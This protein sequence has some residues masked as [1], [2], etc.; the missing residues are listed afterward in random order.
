MGCNQSRHHKDTR[1]LRTEVIVD[2]LGGDGFF[3][4]SE[5]DVGII[6]VENSA[7][8]IKHICGIWRQ[9]HQIVRPFYA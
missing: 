1:S 2:V 3:P 9:L 6:L 7:P 8:T 5:F 4:L